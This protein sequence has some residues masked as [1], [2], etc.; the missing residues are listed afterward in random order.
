MENINNKVELIQKVV[1]ES[2]NIDLRLSMINIAS[3]QLIIETP[4]GAHWDGVLSKILDVVTD[5]L[6]EEYNNR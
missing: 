2:S 4:K 6:K 5:I 1:S 3:V